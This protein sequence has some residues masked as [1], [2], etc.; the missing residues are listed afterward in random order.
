MRVRHSLLIAAALWSAASCG[1][2]TEPANQE[3]FTVSISPK[4]STVAV[5]GTTKFSYTMSVVSYGSNT[6]HQYTASWSSLNTT[7]ATIDQTGTATCNIIGSTTITVVVN[8]TTASSSDQATLG[9]VAHTA[10]SSPIP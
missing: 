7:I 10:S 5:G 2:T 6:N 8:G 4:S 3:S 9:C 1:G